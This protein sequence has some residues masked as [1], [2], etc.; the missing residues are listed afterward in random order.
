MK[1]RDFLRRQDNVLISIVIPVYNAERYITECVDSVCNQSCSYIEIIL[2]DDG[3]KDASGKICDQY[4]RNDSRV[5]VVHK[6]NGGVSSARNVGIETSIGEYVMFVD[7]DDSLEPNAV[8][9]LFDIICKKKD[10]DFIA[11][12]YYDIYSDGTKRIKQISENDTEILETELSS[13]FAKHYLLFTTPWAKLY[14]KKIISD[15]KLRFDETVKYGE[16]M[17]FNMQ[18][19]KHTRHIMI[20][21]SPIYGYR[22]MA[23]GSSQTKYFPHM[24]DYR[25]KAFEATKELISSNCEDIALKFLTT[26][27][28][29]YGLHICEKRAVNGIKRLINYFGMIIPY[30]M[31]EKKLGLI[32]AVLIKAKWSTVF[33]LLTFIKNKTKGIWK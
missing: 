25:I 27:L 9:L 4:A 15:N 23:S 20:L 8:R 30:W 17:I 10:I 24:A 18:Y 5:K 3:S 19:L 26:G 14:K 2:I 1:G 32:K 13:Y 31:L 21:S 7:S 33:F 11:S 28:G 22:L 29:H 16:D 12:A 6:T